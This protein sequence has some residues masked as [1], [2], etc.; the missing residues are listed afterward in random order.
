[1]REEK[2]NIMKYLKF[3]PENTVGQIRDFY[4]SPSEADRELISAFIAETGK[5]TRRI[6][7]S[8]LLLGIGIDDEKQYIQNYFDLLKMQLG[9]QDNEKRFRELFLFYYTICIPELREDRKDQDKM[10]DG[11]SKAWA[12]R[13]NEHGAVDRTEYLKLVF[14]IRPEDTL[15]AA[16]G[17]IFNSQLD[18]RIKDNIAQV[19]DISDSEKEEALRA[20][21]NPDH[22]RILR[23]IKKRNVKYF[24][25]F[26]DLRNLQNI[27]GNAE[28]IL[29]LSEAR[30]FHPGA[31]GDRVYVTDQQR[32][33]G[34][35]DSI[36]L[37]VTCPNVQML[38]MKKANN[39]QRFCVF[40]LDPEEVLKKPC[41]FFAKNAASHIYK[42]QTYRRD[43]MMSYPFFQ[44]MFTFERPEGMPENLP[45][46]FQAEI[47]CEQSIPCS[48]IRA[49][50]F[51][52]E[53]ERQQYAPLFGSAVKCE[54][55]SIYFHG[56]PDKLIADL[57]EENR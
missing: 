42:Q 54:T 31:D 22:E 46:N 4:S 18:E 51:E 47:I 7:A 57:K 44:G 28:G 24:T 26:T 8:A 30:Y 33:D 10:L 6:G 12:G 21:A 29:T 43:K 2:E 1:L 48:A 34:H 25:H 53:K 11:A 38:Y 37:S 20:A 13:R 19:L 40:M 49:V 23:E 36:S 9:E 39:K 55:N 50:Y 16:C 52:N 35:I 27:M 32:L 14:E 5:K 15:R 41:L 3:G 17:K 56:K 45:A